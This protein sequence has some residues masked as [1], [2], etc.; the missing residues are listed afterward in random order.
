MHK[1]DQ[2]DKVYVR[3]DNLHRHIAGVHRGV[4]YTC[5]ISK[6]EFMLK[7][8]CAI[9][10]EYYFPTQVAYNRHLRSHKYINNLCQ[11][12][13]EMPGVSTVETMFKNRLVTLRID[14]TANDDKVDIRK[15]GKIYRFTPE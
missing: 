6:Q 4:K 2:C 7:Y 3:R 10:E 9:C 1:C 11:E 13:S 8:S 14:P 15:F 12:N 5:N